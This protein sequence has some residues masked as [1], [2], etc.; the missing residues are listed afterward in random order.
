[1]ISGM[2]FVVMNLTEFD[3]PLENSSENRITLNR[4]SIIINLGYAPYKW[5]ITP[6][7][8]FLLPTG[9]LGICQNA[10][11]LMR[12]GLIRIQVNEE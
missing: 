10:E 2:V 11:W 3:P 8:L 1:M 6:G 9:T 5:D 12:E 4:G 7:E